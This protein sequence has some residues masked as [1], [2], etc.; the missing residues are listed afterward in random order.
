MGV[1]AI[2]VT[3]VSANVLTA[4]QLN[5]CNTTIY[6]EFNGNIDN[7]NIKAGANIDASKLLNNSI[8][9]SK[10]AA[11]VIADTNLD[12]SSVRVY[13][14]G[15]NAPPSGGNGRRMAVG[16]KAYT[17]ASTATV[18]VT[19]TYSSDAEDGNPQFAAAAVLTFANEHVADANTYDIQITANLA[20]GF[21][22]EIH[23]TNAT[24]AT[25]GTLHWHASGG[26]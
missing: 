16:R 22:V 25:S 14:A 8:T 26:V 20:S 17:F 3:Y 18:S 10:L 4:A 1:V 6:N 15:P 23:S 12:Y 2:P 9:N 7:A 11:S 5:L 24:D 13:R 19:V 21:T